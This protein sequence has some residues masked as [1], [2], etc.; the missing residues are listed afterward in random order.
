MDEDK[1]TRE[2]QGELVTQEKTQ[3][4]VQPFSLAA[5]PI[6]ALEKA[7]RVAQYM[8]AKCSG[9]KFVSVISGRNYPKVDWWT[10]VGMALGLFAQV[11]SVQRVFTDNPKEIKYEAWVAIYHG[12]AR[13][14]RAPH[15]ASSLEGQSWSRSEASIHSMAITRAT[16]KAFRIGL[17]GLAVLAGLEPT[18]AEEMPGDKP[19]PQKARATGPTEKQLEAFDAAMDWAVSAGQL[20]KTAAEKSKAWARGVTGETIGQEIRTWREK[21]AQVEAEEAQDAEPAKTPV[22]P[23]PEPPLEDSAIEKELVAL[24]KQ[25]GIKNERAALLERIGSQYAVTLFAELNKQQV[26]EVK[27]WIKEQAPQGQGALV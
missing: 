27:K 8:A 18:P 24:A 12:A 25:F 20:S 22:H 15:I 4:P 19:V 9:E 11:E 14:G 17:S 16:G 7:S 6:E 13:V 21:K 2:Y 1:T 10:S 23:D 26:D 3:M 5:D